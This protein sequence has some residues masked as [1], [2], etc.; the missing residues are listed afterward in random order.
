MPE[1]FLQRYPFEKKKMEN[2]TKRFVLFYR[3]RKQAHVTN[4]RTQREKYRLIIITKN[5]KQRLLEILYLNLETNTMIS[6][7]SAPLTV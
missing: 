4:E 7:E 2:D 5:K 6:N 3:I 1:T